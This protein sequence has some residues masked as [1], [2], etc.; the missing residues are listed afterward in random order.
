[1]RI[2][3]LGGGFTGLSAAYRLLKK[4]HQV[5]IF[6]KENALGGLAIGFKK[7]G[8][9]WSLEKAYHH[10]FT[11]DNSVL[12]LAKEINHP[13]IVKRP[14]TDIFMRGK[15]L[16]FDSLTSVLRF[17]YLTL[18]DKLRLGFF[19]IYLKLTDNYRSFE[20]QKALPWIKKF[21]GVK[22]TNLIWDPLFTGKFG[23][24]KDS[25]ALTWFWARIKKRTP[26]LA[27]PEGGFEAFTQSLA[28]KIENQGGNINLNS[29]V[30]KIKSNQ[31]KCSLEVNGKNFSFDKI[32][33]TLPSPIF[34]RLCS[35]LPKTYVKK[36]SSILHLHALILILTFK[37]PFMNSTYWL[38]ITDKQ[39]PFLVLAEHTNFMNPKHYDNEH[40]LYI[41]NYLPSNHP[42]LKMSKEQLLKIFMPYLKKINQTSDF[43]VLTSHLFIGPFAQPI[44]TT[45]YPKLIPHFKTPLPNI[46]LANLDMVYPWDRGTNYAVELGE[47]VTEIVLKDET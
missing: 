23:R 46:Y 14:S 2:A 22:V 42:Y 21:M 34:I 41:G 24:Y 3:I 44:V 38:N 19:V 28:Q 6:E 4:G 40:I 43:S 7:P 13:V 1:M 33:I 32:I 17:P 11:N 16:P 31:N 25:I 8:W 35:E 45:A 15:R 39:F 5:T 10:W 36:I 20:G 30:T 9:Q 18:I 29:L 37:K 12:N 26:S 47:K 27:Y